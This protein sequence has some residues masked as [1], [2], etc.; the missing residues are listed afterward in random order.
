MRLTGAL[1]IGALERAINEVVARQD[2]LRAAFPVIAGQPR[3]IVRHRQQVPLPVTD[4]RGLTG[5][6]RPARVRE[7]TAE[8]TRHRFSLTDGPL[9]ATRLL[10]LDDETHLLLVGVHHIVFDGWS[11]A[12]FVTELAE[13]YAA[14]V[15]GRPVALAALPVRYVEW[16][17]REGEQL[18]GAAAADRLAY[19]RR[20]LADA[21]ARSTFPTDL[22]RPAVQRNRGQQRSARLP[23]ELTTRLAAL[24]RQRG[25]TLN[26]VLLAGLTA[27]LHRETGQRDILIG[28][29]V[30]G[31][32]T[33]DLE[34]LIGCFAN[35]VVF[36]FDLA[37]DP[38]VKELIARAHRTVGAA[39]A[40]QEAPYASV[41]EAAA[42]PRDPAHNPLFQIMFSVATISE[43]PRRAGG[44]TFT[45]TDVESESTD[46]D[47]FLT[48]TNRDGELHGTAGYDADLFLPGTVDGIVGNLSAVLTDF[49]N[50]PDR[51]LSRL[52]SLRQRR[53]TVATSFTADPIR[54]P[55]D[56]WSGFL[57]LPLGVRFEAYSQLLPHLLAGELAPDGTVCL[58]RWEDWLR[59]GETPEPGAAAV[60]L[61]RVVTDLGAGL[62][63]VRD[64]TAA[65]VLVGVCPPSEAYAGQPW[66]RILAHLDDRLSRSC[67]QLPDVTFF[68]PT[69]WTGRYPVTSVHDRHADALGQIPYTPAFFAG[70]GTVVVRHLARYWTD[71][72]TELVVQK[73]AVEPAELRRLL[74]GQARCGRR[75][76]VADPDGLAEAVA[77]AA[78]VAASAGPS[79]VLVLA[80]DGFAAGRLTDRFPTVAVLVPPAGPTDRFLASLW[81]LDPP[82]GMVPDG[83]TIGIDPDRLAY[84]AGHLDS[85]AAVAERLRPAT[86]A[87]RGD[88]SAVA[89][90]TPTEHRLAA[91]WRQVLPGAEIDVHEDFFS[92]GGHSLLAVALLSAVQAEFDRRIEL[93]TFFTGPTIGHLG[94]VLDQGAE[95]LDPIPVLPRGG[96]LLP[97]STQ[98]RLWAIA[99]LGDD[100]TRHNI[101]FAAILRGHLD[102]AVLRR[103]VDLVVARHEVLRV[104]FGDRDGAPVSVVHDRVDCWLPLVDVTGESAP[105]RERAVRD[106]LDSF[107]SHRYDLAAGPLLLVRLVRTGPAEHRLFVG[108]HHIVSDNWSWGIF[109]RE[110]AGLYERELGGREAGAGQAGGSDPLPPLP[111]QFADVAAWQ[112]QRQRRA[113]ERHAEHWR[114]RL[115]GAPVLTLPTDRPRPAVRSDRS[116]RAVWTF[117]AGIGTGLRA[118]AQQEGGTLF[119]AALAGFAALLTERAGQPELM[120]GTPVSGRDR[121]ELDGLIGYFADL[122]PLR[123]DISGQPTFRELTRRVRATV[124]D[125][126][127]HQLPFGAI[128]DAVRPPR[129]AAHHPIFQCLFNVVDSPDEAL[130]L[131][132]LAVLPVEV[133]PT[134][135]DFDL[136]LTLSWRDADAGAPQRL[137]ATLD[138]RVD[139]FEPATAER[140]LA[141]LADLLAG[142]LTE[143]WRRLGRA[144]YP[145]PTGGSAPVRVVEPPPV[146]ELTV[147]VAASF[148]ADPLRDAARYWFD[149]TALPVRLEFGPYAQVFQQLLDPDAAF[150]A[151]IDGVSVLLLRWEDWLRGRRTTEPGDMPPAATAL[152]G[153][154]FEFVAAVEAFRGRTPAPL[155]VLICPASERFRQPPWSGLFTALTRRLAHLLDR[156]ADVQV[157]RIDPELRRYA[158]REQDDPVGEELAHL[159]YTTEA[160]AVLGTVLAREVYRCGD[161]HPAAMWPPAGGPS[162]AASILRAVAGS[163][164][165]SGPRSTPYLGPRDDRE[166]TLAAIFAEL[167]Q[168]DQ[169]GVTDSFW[170]LGGDSMVAIQVVS[171]AARAG[172]VITPRQ[173]LSQP[174]VAELAVASA[175]RIPADGGP[176]QGPAAGPLTG[177]LPLTPPQHWFFAELA[178]ALP[179]PAHFNHPYDL[180]L[181]RPVEPALLREALTALV[182][183]HDMLRARFRFDGSTWH[184]HY[185]DPAEPVAFVSHDLTGLPADE[186]AAALV[187]LATAE[188]AGL[189]LADGPLIR[190]AHFRLTADGPDRLLI[191]NHHLVVDA[192]SRGV[193]LADLQVLCEQLAEGRRPRL[194]AKS[195]SYRDWSRRLREFAGSDTL[196]GQLDF[197]LGQGAPDGGRLP[198]DHPGAMGTFGTSHTLRATLDEAETA[199]LRRAARRLGGKL[200][201]LLAAF[202]ACLIADWTG[203]EGAALALAGHGRSDL[204]PETD[205][206]RTV[207]WFQVYYPRRLDVPAPA[208][209]ATST[210]DRLV[211]V[212]GQ[213]ADVPDNG[214]GYGL[215]RYCHPDPGVRQRLARLPAPQVTYNY[216]GDFSFA[217]TPDGTDLFEVPAEPAGPPQDEN[218]RWPYV[219]DVVPSIVDRCLG[220]DINYSENLYRRKTVEHLLDQLLD[221]MRVFLRQADSS[222]AADQ[223]GDLSP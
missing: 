48:L 218:G 194:P 184:Q 165:R 175:A 169:V 198:V 94:S 152:T 208:T 67:R 13:C 156:L 180:T 109:L 207:G 2:A 187:E 24:A 38:D 164:D 37:G 154:L 89:P 75:V 66:T 112:E 168:V 103:A 15:A 200:G 153:Q 54:P 155:R 86:R 70:L 12:V 209:G 182:R 104:T 21:P 158:V 183:Q 191:V 115:D 222:A 77:V 206:S 22:P 92:A 16:T 215:L 211:T 125:A 203:A 23:A 110:V 102:V 72:V 178:P 161:R 36:R 1:D 41:V 121:P 107:T 57:R 64:R 111:V 160:F 214:I 210:Q 83:P 167:L 43:E 93:H 143:P 219:L 148:T 118:L 223:K 100:P 124:V 9:L 8:H 128:V 63:A 79:G 212:L 87:R 196:A 150:G 65:P 201:D 126:Y 162:D 116:A 6:D 80:A 51:K 133:P 88:E 157:I 91:L 113:V 10:P 4:L 101:T 49:V 106:Q 26:T 117:A 139:I 73:G 130:V 190:A 85:A 71:P 138:Y 217:G 205:L 76:T 149:R 56:F 181:R 78:R 141:D 159:P 50:H 105:G 220:I 98:R 58:L 30:A 45:P 108:I 11:T 132:G 136:F 114:A 84:L 61:D 46:F 140:L 188:Q 99:Q 40:H 39:Y 31:R 119:H 170:E 192:M 166:E 221:Q 202:T 213:L 195:T 5:G 60:L 185:A 14:E 144:R 122:L 193:L 53:I 20:Q 34:P 142:A 135:I 19:W 52:E 134:G 176:A 69:T 35:T 163:A 18:G 174:T 199:L 47:L 146:A 42:P 151:T 32:L 62:R 81:P 97:S 186:R 129:D 147:A 74:D 95:V 127:A 25:T 189:H 177:E 82:A 137:H 204:F 90:R 173:L 120:V 7:I 216:M 27:L 197:W 59:H 29:P 55:L 172:V 145:V 17:D 179:N 131:P 96:D 28:S 3:Q 68:G 123:V 33:A 171:R 44:V